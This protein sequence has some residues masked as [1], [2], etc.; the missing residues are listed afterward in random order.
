MIILNRVRHR[1]LLHFQANAVM[2]WRP[3]ASVADQPCWRSLILLLRERW[4]RA[5][6]VDF[7]TPSAS[8]SSPP[9][10]K[11]V[12]SGWLRMNPHGLKPQRLLMPIYSALKLMLVPV[13]RMISSGASKPSAPPQKGLKYR[14]RLGESLPFW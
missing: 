12:L 7:A 6:R 4:Y 2:R 8:I 3:M 9:V 14:G 1:V 13:T 10:R 11:R 5:P